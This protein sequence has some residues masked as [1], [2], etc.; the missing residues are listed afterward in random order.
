MKTQ[1][2]IVTLLVMVFAQF[3]AMAQ[4]GV[5]LRRPISP[6][7]PMWLIHIDTWNYADPQKII[8]LI[9]PDIRPFVVM[10]ISLSISH[11]ETT[12]QFQV[13][14]YGYEVAKSW[15]RACA[16]NRMWAIVQPSS[17]GF[18]Q[19]SDFDMSVYEEF[20]RDYPN[21]I[22]F[23]YCEQFWG[24]DSPTDPLSA[25][26]TDRIAHFA[27]LLKLSN[28]NG[29][30]LVV[31][32]CGNQ[33]SPNINPIAML[34]RDPNFAPACRDYTE[35]YILCEK[36]TQQSYQADM[37]SLCLGAYLSG[38][39]GQ[40]GIRYDDTGWTDVNGNH[41]SF[42]MAT[43]GAPQLEHMM[44]TGQTVVDGPELIWTQCFRE[45]SAGSTTDGYSMRRWNTFPQFDNVSVDLFRKVL[46]GTVRIPSRK[47]VIDR[48]KVVVIN[49]VNSGGVDTVYSSPDTQ[50]EGLYRMDGDGNL[51]NNKTFFKKTGRYPAVPTVFALD[52]A[53]AN[54][55][56]VKVNRSAY[57]SRWP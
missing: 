38:Y 14:E 16:E 22:G 53:D 56:P 55:F 3:S 52:D 8:A 5:P 48:T 43:A 46:D 47:E 45:I 40:Y 31:S 37:E 18:S 39:A 29:G 26:W 30:Y 19:F 27:N 44:L 20:Y 34:K 10:N 32:W 51:L 6:D 4:T 36:Y 28:R 12:S 49:N 42:T 23:N 7:K 11:N 2:L 35:N 21:F 9:P 24:Y 17:G 1:F 13:A 57:A 15:L 33:W 25:K 41:A 50:F 54:S